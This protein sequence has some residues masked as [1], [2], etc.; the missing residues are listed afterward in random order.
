M[1]ELTMY[2]NSGLA[3][4]AFALIVIIVLLFMV[5]NLCQER[6]ELKHSI[7][8]GVSSQPQ[9][10]RKPAMKNEDLKVSFGIGDEVQQLGQARIPGIVTAVRQIN[11]DLQYTVASVIDSVYQPRVWSRLELKLL[12]RANVESIAMAFSLMY[13]AM[14]F[15]A[16][17]GLFDSFAVGDVVKISLGDST[18][19]LVTSV[20]SKQ[21][22][23]I[24][25]LECG[26]YQIQELQTRRLEV[27]SQ[28]RLP[29]LEPSP[30]S[31]YVEPRQQRVYSTCY[32]APNATSVSLYGQL[33]L[34]CARRIARHSASS[35]TFTGDVRLRL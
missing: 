23:L 30:I 1:N 31:Q 6:E 9:N 13:S 16:R 21:G 20:G 19:F 11:D 2:L 34:L 27:G 10:P 3:I 26:T 12:R 22:D 15:T 4:M 17:S 24:Y 18:S 7:E 33:L 32:G 35:S 28:G 14:N 5:Y 25:V 29:K 8:S